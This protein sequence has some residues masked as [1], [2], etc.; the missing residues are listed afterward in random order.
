MSALTLYNVDLAD[1]LVSPQ[2]FTDIDTDSPALV[3]FTDFRLHEPL[4]IDGWTAATQAGEFMRQSHTHMRLVVDH[5]GEFIGTISMRDLSQE[6]LLKQI[7]AG[8]RRQEIRV[9][10][11]MTQRRHLRALSYGDV[12]NATVGDI[13]DTLRH[14]GE[15]HCLVVNPETHGI[16]GLIAASDVA[17]RL[18]R[19]IDVPSTFSFAEAFAA[20]RPAGRA[21]QQ[22]WPRRR[23][24]AAR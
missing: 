1:H 5:G 23:R 19:R 6:R 18:H 8:E 16:R 9:M 24:F 13:V 14:Y 20:M 17:R 11:L 3:L 10:D 21:P 2:D 22:S 4:I 12:C 7:A 15:Q